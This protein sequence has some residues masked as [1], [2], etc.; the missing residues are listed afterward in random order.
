MLFWLGHAVVH[1]VDWYVSC[2]QRRRYSADLI[3]RCPA[4]VT[5]Q[6]THY[7][8]PL[9]CMLP[10]WIGELCDTNGAVGG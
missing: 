7:V 8:E 10:V 3:G 1:S 6:Y 5:G 2:C 9:Q 4:L